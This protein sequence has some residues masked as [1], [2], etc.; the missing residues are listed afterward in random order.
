VSRRILTS[1]RFVDLFENFDASENSLLF[2]RPGAKVA[3][4]G[5]PIVFAGSGAAGDSRLNTFS[6][7]EQDQP[8]G[9]STGAGDDHL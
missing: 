8:Y 1:E 4:Q 7:L 5:W 3:I 9:G 6:F 2:R